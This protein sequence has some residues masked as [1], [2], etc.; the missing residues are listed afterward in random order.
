MVMNYTL[1]TSP[2]F[3]VSAGGSHHCPQGLRAAACM[4]GA[5]GELQAANTTALGSACTPGYHPV[6]SAW[7]GLQ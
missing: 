4:E 1:V 3:P 7:S 6:L 5:R 2:D